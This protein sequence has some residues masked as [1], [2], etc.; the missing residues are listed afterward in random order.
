M[1]H[2]TRELIE[3]VYRFYPRGARGGVPGPESSEENRRLLDTKARAA[4]DLGRFREMLDRLTTR[5][6]GSSV[7]ETLYLIPY[8][9][10][11]WDACL[12]ANLKLPTVPPQ[13]G[14]HELVMMV[15]VLVPYYLLYSSIHFN[16][17]GDRF[18]RAKHARSSWIFTPAERPYVDE[19]AREIE[20]TYGY[21][22]MS[23]EIGRLTVPLLEP[24]L[25]F[26]DVWTLFD[27]FFT[28]GIVA[29]A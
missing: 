20:T 12:Q 11:H 2:T 26:T 8:G 9:P 15:S 19:V 24:D 17:K 3:L 22:R 28:T 21:E 10:E 18:G 25:G 23:P 14:A 1:K 6:S 29:E 5:I 13:D 7:F 4:A 16:I 27:Y